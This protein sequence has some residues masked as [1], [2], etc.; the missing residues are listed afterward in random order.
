MLLQPGGQAHVHFTVNLGGVTQ[1]V[2]VVSAVVIR[3]D[4]VTSIVPVISHVNVEAGIYVVGFAVPANW[5]GYDQAFVQFRILHNH[6]L[7]SCTKLAGVVAAAGLDD[8]LEINIDRILDL[9]E[10]DEV[11]I[12]NKLYKR[13]AGTTTVLLE[14]DVNGST[15]VD[16]V[17]LIQP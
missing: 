15:C 13:L 10:A 11:K 1:D 12:G 8:A 7:T 2:G 4:V 6:A 5:V 9:L 17:S 14:K 16:D 3:N